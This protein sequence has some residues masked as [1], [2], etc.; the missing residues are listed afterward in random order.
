MMLQLWWK[1]GSGNIEKWKGFVA[2]A[3]LLILWKRN[4][5]QI[6]NNIVK[7]RTKTVI[8]LT[9]SIWLTFTCSKSTI[10]SLEKGV[11]YVQSRQ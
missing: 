5:L 6:Q 7:I 8:G 11:K 10:K 9:T 2:V 4:W 3:S 1:Y